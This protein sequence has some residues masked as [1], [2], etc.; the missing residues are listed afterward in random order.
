MQALKEIAKGECEREWLCG[1]DLNDDRDMSI[2]MK[3]SG[4]GRSHNTR[5]IAPELYRIRARVCILQRVS[6]EC[7]ICNRVNDEKR[8]REL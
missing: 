6:A 8:L 7:F 2:T 1:I 4:R 3:M 5:D